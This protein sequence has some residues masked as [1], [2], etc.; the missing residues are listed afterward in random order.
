[1]TARTD[2]VD[3]VES[4]EVPSIRGPGRPRR[5]DPELEEQI[6]LD[7]GLK[8]MRRNGY[9]MASVAD[10]LTEADVSSRAFYRHFPSK[11]ALLL[12]LLRRDADRVVVQMRAA[13]SEATTPTRAVHAYLDI[14]FEPRRAARTAVMSSPGARRAEGFDEETQAIQVRLA[15][16]LAAALAQGTADGELASLDPERDAFAILVIMGTVTGSLGLSVKP[17]DRSS[18]RRFA[19]RFISSAIGLNEG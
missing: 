11:D 9:V 6:I 13:V 12:A 3:N 8:V 2:P 17:L 10:I 16:P 19:L 4:L 5:F 1:M 14:F 7:A 15:E 18:A